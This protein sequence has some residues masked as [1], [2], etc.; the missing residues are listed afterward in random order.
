MVRRA[1]PFVLFLLLPLIPL[2]NCIAQGQTIGAFDQIRQFAPWNASPPEQPWDVLAADSVLQFYPWR[3][4]VLE[5]WSRGAIPEWNPYELGGTP[6]LANSQSGGLYPPHILLGWLRTSAPLAILMLAWFHLA[7]AGIG[8][9][10]LCRRLGATNWG[11]AIGGGMFSLSAFMISWTML[12]SVISTVAWIPWCLWAVIDNGSRFA[13]RSALIALPVA[14]MLLAGHLQFAAYG[15]GATLFLGLWNSLIGVVEKRPVSWSALGSIWFGLAL[16][17]GLASPQLLPVLEHGKDSHRAGLPTEQGYQSY[18]GTAI[19]VGE[20]LGRLAYPFAFGDPTKRVSSELPISNYYPAADSRGANFAERSST[21]GAVVLL[22]AFA[23]LFQRIKHREVIPLILMGGGALLFAIGTPLNRLFYFYVPG[24]SS[25][26]SPGR[27]IFLLVLALCVLASLFKIPELDAREVKPVRFGTGIIALIFLALFISQKFAPVS[28]MDPIAPVIESAKLGISLLDPL[29][30]VIVGA[31]IVTLNQRINHWL[32]MGL[33]I[34]AIASTIPLM[35]LIRTGTPLERVGD[36]KFVRR[37][38]VVN[39]RWEIVVPA[40]GVVLP[41]NTATILRIPEIGGY[42]SI[43]SRATVDR[44]RKVDNGDPA[45]PANG[46]MMF[47]K[48]AFDIEQLR[49][50]GVTEVWSTNQMD[51]IGELISRENN[52][53]RY[54]I[55]GPGIA[56]TPTKFARVTR[57]DTSGMEVSAE[58]PGPL[59]IRVPNSSNWTA[60]VD[61]KRSEIGNGE[62]VEIPLDEGPHVVTLEYRSARLST[63]PFGFALVLLFTDLISAGIYRRRFK[64]PDK[65]A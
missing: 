55:R 23:A 20:V 29:V 2:W 32:P 7:M 24:W 48:P 21:V 6:L 63:F 1:W 65:S 26:G 4:L 28:A 60:R 50:T 36:P 16:G 46:N 31:L 37:I 59:T 40:P 52:M 11:G 57:M 45:P 17:F 38:G 9:Y 5:S 61:G 19:P 64:K 62:Y 42:D 58:G 33:L 49:A 25:T 15:L 18:V 27:V 30:L 8:T 34:M 39:D 56:S 41:P 35:H 51:E 22:L 3:E 14:L 12:P 44:L 47:L 10:L 43:V 54:F 53:N 13:G